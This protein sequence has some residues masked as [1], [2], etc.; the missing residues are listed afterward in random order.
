MFDMVLEDYLRYSKYS[1]TVSRMR[2][3]DIKGAEMLPLNTSMSSDKIEQA[4]GYR[5]ASFEYWARTI[6]REMLRK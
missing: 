2:L 4:T 6:V 1:G 3:H 5:A